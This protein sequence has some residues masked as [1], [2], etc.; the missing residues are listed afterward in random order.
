MSLR[1][2]LTIIKQ[3][4]SA[5][6]REPL[7]EFALMPVISQKKP[8]S[9]RLIVTDDDVYD[10]LG[11]PSSKYW[12]VFEVLEVITRS[13]C[14]VVC[15]QKN[16]TEAGIDVYENHVEGFGELS[17]RSRETFDYE[18]ILRTT[19]Y[20]IIG[21]GDGNENEFSF[22]LPHTDIPTF[23]RFQL[24]VGSKLI[25]LVNDGSGGLTAPGYTG[26]INYATGEIVITAT[27]GSVGD[28]AQIVGTISLASPL[29]FSGGNNVAI[30]LEIDQVL[31][32]NIDLGNNAS[33]ASSAI[34][35]AINTEV[36][37]TVAALSTNF[38]QLT[39]L[40]RSKQLGNVNIL[41]PT[42]LVTY[43]NG[44]P[45]IFGTS[46]EGLGTD[47]TGTIPKAGQTV[48]VRTNIIEDLSELVSH[49]FL[50]ISPNALKEWAIEL[51]R[52]SVDDP[53]YRLSLYKLNKQGVPEFKEDY[54]YSLLEKLD[55]SGRSLYIFDVFTDNRFIT[56]VVNENYIGDLPSADIEDSGIVELTGN[57]EGEE[58]E[59]SD[60]QEALEQID[61]SITYPINNMLDPDGQSLFLMLSLRNVS[62][63]KAHVASV[64]PFSTP[65][66]GLLAYRQNLGLNTEQATLT[67][68]WHKIQDTFN[69]STAWISRIGGVGV[70]YAKAETGFDQPSIAG[71]DENGYG[72]LVDKWRVLE[73]QFKFNNTELRQYRQEQLNPWVL[74]RTRGIFLYGDNTLLRGESA[75]SQ[76]GPAR[77]TN[78]I[79]DTC[80][81]QILFLQLFKNNDQFHRNLVVDRINNYLAPIIAGGFLFNGVPVANTKNNNGTVR[82]QKKFVLD[83]VLQIT[84]NTQEIVFRITQLNTGQVISDFVQI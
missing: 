50:E 9:P 84:E 60:I 83:L 33:T 37:E 18:N 40:I 2:R 1:D 3:D 23:A 64:V 49:S 39:G 17:G 28:F 53:D 77:L 76:T 36:G 80:Y 62:H 46:E 69:N 75:L 4:F 24:K 43:I 20:V 34:L 42:D 65:K 45:L 66:S 38:L 59:L 19:D 8:K 27:Q 72:G 82:A 78:R 14:W 5:V 68:N 73:M 70:N 54:I 51:E 10:Y 25:E 26:T 22:T 32:E 63:P 74:D 6:A 56:P 41:P 55:G 13:P 81:E 21:T 29:D 7:G 52:I 16:A 57:F 31:Y 11:N 61:D 15:P 71:I 58:A 35:T 67:F 47:S 30:N 44:V 79:I 12:Q 48:S